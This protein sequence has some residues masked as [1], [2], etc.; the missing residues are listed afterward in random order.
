MCTLVL[1]PASNLICSG[2]SFQC[3]LNSPLSS[4]KMCS[5]CD[6]LRGIQS[7][8]DFRASKFLLDGLPKVFGEPK[9]LVKHVV[10]EKL[11]HVWEFCHKIKGPC[12]VCR[13]SNFVG[14][15]LEVYV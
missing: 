1:A 12:R 7:P 2:L 9:P 15:I 10:P 6:L 13:I 14:S 11:Q 4:C 5:K 3:T 8:H